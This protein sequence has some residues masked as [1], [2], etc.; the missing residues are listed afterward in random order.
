VTCRPKPCEP[1]ATCKF[2]ALSATT[3]A[4]VIIGHPLA[5]QFAQW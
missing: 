2:R 4:T 1:A 5:V 3:S